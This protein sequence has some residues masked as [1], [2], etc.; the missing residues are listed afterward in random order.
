VGEPPER[1][2]VGRVIKAHGVR[3]EVVVE[4]LSEVPERFARG[5][6][7]EA[8]ELDGDRRRLTVRATRSDRGKLLVAF[9]EVRDRDAADALRGGLLSIDASQAAPPGTGSYYP[10]QLEGL[11]VV[12]E[13]GV[14]LGRL[15]RVEEGA[16]SDFWIVDTGA[17]EVMVPAVDEFVRRVDLEVRRIVVHTIPGL[18][19]EPHR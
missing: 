19:D 6:K 11:A 8:G 16:A 13:D 3:G 9:A 15:A 1:L 17:G 18:F 2:V 5:S 14:T 10:W 4:V 12:D 7:V